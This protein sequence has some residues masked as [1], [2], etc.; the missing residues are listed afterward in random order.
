[1]QYQAE[2]WR[3]HYPSSSPA[4]CQL[5]ARTWYSLPCT[6]DKVVLAYNGLISVDGFVKFVAA[7]TVS[8]RVLVL[9]TFH[10]AAAIELHVIDREML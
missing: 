3:R 7:I 2:Q 10:N 6:D 1:M 4:L 8:L 5:P 9:Y